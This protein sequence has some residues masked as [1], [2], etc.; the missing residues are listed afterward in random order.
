MAVQPYL[1]F[2]GRCEEALDFY[3][4]ALG[5]QVTMLMRYR[6]NPEALSL[7]AEM[8]E[9]VMHASFSIGETTIM[10]SDGQCGGV[11]NFQGFAM[12]LTLESAAEVERAFAALAVEGEVKMPLEKTFFS[13]RFGMVAD[14]FGVE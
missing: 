1:F 4:Q 5:A 6:E 7:P 11:T 12:S 9:K 13:P 2:E 14:R 3:S 8:G 10:A